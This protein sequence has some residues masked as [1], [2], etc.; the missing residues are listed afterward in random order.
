[1]KFLIALTIHLVVVQFD[2]SVS[3]ILSA[4]VGL[5][6]TLFTTGPPRNVTQCTAIHNNIV[7]SIYPDLNLTNA[8]YIGLK[9]RCNFYIN[10]INFD[11]AGNWTIR[12]NWTGVNN[13]N[14]QNVSS[15]ELYINQGVDPIPS[16]VFDTVENNYLTVTSHDIFD[17]LTNCTLMQRF[18]RTDVRKYD[19]FNPNVINPNMERIGRCGVRMHI[20]ASKY[21]A[22][23]IWEASGPYKNRKFSF[24]IRPPPKRDTMNEMNMWWSLGSYKEI[25]LFD[26]FASRYCTLTQP[27]GQ[28]FVLE[29]NRCIH[30]IPEVGNS[31]NGLWIL[32]YL[33]SGSL[34]FAERRFNIHVYNPD[35]VN[36]TVNTT[37]TQRFHLMCRIPENDLYFCVFTRPDGMTINLPQGIGNDKYEYYGNGYKRSS[38]GGY[39]DCGITIRQ[40]SADDFGMW[41]CSLGLAGKVLSALVPVRDNQTYNGD[42]FISER[43]YIKRGNELTVK[44]QTS[45]PIEYCWLKSPNGT[46][47]LLSNSGSSENTLPYDSESLAVGVCAARIKNATDAHTGNWSCRLGVF[48]GGEVEVV[49][50]VTVTDS[51]LYPHQNVINMS[52]EEKSILTCNVSPEKDAIIRYCRWLRP[53][54]RTIFKEKSAQYFTSQERKSCSLHLKEYN[55]KNIGK[56]S[57]YARLYDDSDEEIYATITV[58]SE[59]KYNGVM[60]TLLHIVASSLLTITLVGC[61][62]VGIIMYRRKIRNRKQIGYCVNY[63]I[64]ENEV[65]T[66]QE[67]NSGI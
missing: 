8:K 21:G 52:D 55:P 53:D 32:R 18:N 13:V 12:M 11:H 57:C 24:T 5:S 3:T 2:Q 56:W 64:H 41:K 28:I 50:P 7:Y 36:V 33:V 25:G 63:E 43:T 27:D 37:S 4:T 65:K 47:Y 44:C 31:H 67:K 51:Y 39:S 26:L 17:N 30:R 1:M 10:D 38:R 46:V 48:E 45:A 58:I 42:K 34:D 20:D 16:D 61:C 29:N 6:Q 15:I 49:V 60:G 22:W 19:L 59:N 40:P 66:T 54:Y 23:H 9:E 35:F 62:I 14:Y